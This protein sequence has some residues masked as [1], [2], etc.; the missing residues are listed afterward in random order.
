[1]GAMRPPP[2]TQLAPSYY[3][4]SWAEPTH[5]RRHAVCYSLIKNWVSVATI[6]PKAPCSRCPS[7]LGAPEAGGPEAA[8]QAE[9]EC[10]AA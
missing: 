10:A 6:L 4:R 9:G 5:T 8:N 3:G 7:P 1:M 2:A